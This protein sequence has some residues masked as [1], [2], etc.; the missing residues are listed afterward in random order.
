MPLD[1]LLIDAAVRGGLSA[2]C[3]TCSKYWEG[4]DKGLPEPTCT[5]KG[6]CGSPLA[7]DDFREYDGPMVAFERYCFVCAENSRYGVRVRG[8]PRTI[9]VCE[10]H[11][12]MLTTL[13]PVSGPAASMVVQ[14]SDG[15]QAR[16]EEVVPEPKKTLFQTIAETE[17]QFEGEG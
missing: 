16:P 5:A 4:R 17:K 2:V 15:K 11:I 8:R 13:R 6:R 1:P 7:G 9:G 3:A 14:G 10:K 12:S